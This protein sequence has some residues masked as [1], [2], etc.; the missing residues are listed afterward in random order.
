MCHCHSLSVISQT[1]VYCH[2]VHLLFLRRPAAILRA[3]IAVY[4]NAVNGQIIGV[5]AFHGPRSEHGIIVP[6]RTDF[7]ALSSVLL[8]PLVCGFAA[9]A[10]HIFPRLIKPFFVRKSVLSRFATATD[11][12]FAFE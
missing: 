5:T 4:V 2:V 10:A 12:S 9:T 11:S 1:P 8:P 6:F 7:Y 3:V